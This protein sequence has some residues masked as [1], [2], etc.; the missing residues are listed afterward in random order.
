LEGGPQSVGGDFS[1]SSN[2]V[3]LTK[4]PWLK[5]KGRFVN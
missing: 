3:K 5:V 1:C 4:P 2:P